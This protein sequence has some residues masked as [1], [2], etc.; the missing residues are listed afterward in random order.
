M[1]YFLYLNLLLLISACASS[2][3]PA[4]AVTKEAAKEAT[5]RMQIAETLSSVTIGAV[6][7]IF[8]GGTATP[9]LE[10]EGYDHPFEATKKLFSASDIIIG[11]LEAPLTSRGIPTPDKRYIFRTPADKVA[12]ALKNAGFNI[13]TLANNHSM[14]YG[15]LGLQ[16]TIKALKQHQIA[17]IG[18]GSSLTA[19]REPYIFNIN[20]LRVGFLGYSLTFPEEYWADETR[21]GTAF[22]REEQMREDLK[23]LRVKADVIVVSFHWGREQ[24]TKLRPYQSRMGRIAI[25]EGASLVLGHHPHIMQGIEAYKKGLIVYSLGNYVFGSFSNRVQYGGLANIELDSA[26]FKSM[27]LNIL[28]VNNFRQKFQPELMKEKGLKDALEQ[29]IKLSEAQNTAL[30]I[31][32][33][34]LILSRDVLSDISAQP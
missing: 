5:I 33:E 22:A 6:G 8:M 21:G 7:D 4:P 11:N 13:V 30:T 10:T 18:A 24:Q 23:R 16:D 25:D 34:Q 29:L 9:T 15:L 31:R 12:P 17:H 3:Q 14:D 27:Q 2:P 28:D 19:A 1:R 26:G 32:G 20:S